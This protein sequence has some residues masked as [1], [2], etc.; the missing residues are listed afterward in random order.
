MQI[1]ITNL[2]TSKER[3]LFM[4]KQFEKLRIP[5]RFF[6]CVVGADLSEEEINQKCDFNTIN[7]L[8]GRKGWFNKGIIGCTLTNQN[9]YKEIIKKNLDYAL[10]LEDD[11]VL[12]SNLQS[13]LD[14]IETFIRQGDVIL[15]FFACW[16]PLQLKMA[17]EAPGGINYFTLHNPEVITGGSAFV[18]TKEA[19][20]RM[21]AANTPIQR[22]PDYWSFFLKKNCIDRLLCAFPRPVGTADF[23]STMGLGK[24]NFVRNLIDEYKIFPF[25]H[26]LKMRRRILKQKK[27]KV[28][29]IE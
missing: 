5:Y 22:T 9:I 18:V 3:R 29:I 28:T 6:D 1:Y 15:L 13:I 2:H 21:L 10:L 26:I 20:G 16:E 25:F 23:K 12:P 19:A 14:H 8:K 7:Q 17:I 4:E 27:G 24:F 11:T